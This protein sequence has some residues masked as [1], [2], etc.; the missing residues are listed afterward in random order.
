MPT[1]F[2]GLSAALPQAPWTLDVLAPAALDDPPSPYPLYSTHGTG[3]APAGHRGTLSVKSMRLLT[4]LLAVIVWG[5]LNGYAFPP[6]P[7]TSDYK[8][9][10]SKPGG[11]LQGPFQVSTN[12]GTCRQ[13]GRIFGGHDIALELIYGANFVRSAA[14]FELDPIN[15]VL[16]PTFAKTR[17]Q[18]S[19]S[20]KLK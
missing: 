5:V 14:N 16:G 13:S 15:D 12:R 3:T 10:L 4:A 8:Q 7:E 9:T 6:N 1:P 17:P 18:N 20:L 19:R 2:T 11:F